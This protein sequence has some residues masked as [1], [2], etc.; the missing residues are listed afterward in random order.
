MKYAVFVEGKSELLFVAHLLQEYYAYNSNQLGLLCFSRKSKHV[1][2]TLTYPKLG[3]SNSQN[4][5]QIYNV[6]NDNSVVSMIRDRVEHLSDAGFDTI[7]GL[8]DAYSRELRD[9][10]GESPKVDLNVI[11]D[12]HAK[13][14]EAMKGNGY[15]C[16]LHFAIMELESWMLCLIENELISHGKL[17]DDLNPDLS[18]DLNGDIENELFHPASNLEEVYTLL[19]KTY[20]KKTHD[21]ES[22]LSRL[23]KNDFENLRH[24]GRSPSFTK[25]VDSLLGSPCPLLP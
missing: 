20:N 23:N 11:R 18:F 13:Q 17:I 9:M 24:S 19:G 5:Y 1:A 15:D 16:R 25:F 4:Y 8:R 21:I 22:F 12:L 10:M 2:Q 6:G 3:D 14:V 7:I